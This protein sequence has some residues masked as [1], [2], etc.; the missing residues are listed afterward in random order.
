M[1]FMN[2][3]QSAHGDREFGYITARLGI[4]RKVVAGHV[5]DPATRAR[6][7]SWLSAATGWH[8]SRNL[9][10]A[11]FGDNMRDVAVTDG[12]RVEAQ[13]TFGWSIQGHSI[14]DLV[15]AVRAASDE[16]VDALTADYEQ[17][18]AVVP[19]LRSGGE[20]HESLRDAA[21]IEAGLRSFL[22]E[23][24]LR[25]V[26]HQLPG[27]GRA[28]AAARDRAAEADG[29]RLRL[30]RRGRLEDSCP[31]A[32][33]EGHGQRPHRRHL[34]HG[35]LHLPLRSRRAA[36]P[37]R[38]HARDLPEHHLTPAAG[39]DPSAGDRRPRGSRQTRVRRRPR[40]RFRRRDPRPRR[41]LPAR[42]QHH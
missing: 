5:G 3:N 2:L 7:G 27:S 16:T 14:N 37:R 26:H 21:R 33:G 39:R 38:A 6:I 23:N 13:R 10:V 11:R 25:R 30:R 15:D 18:Y 41:P 1:D 4:R 34:L 42:R 40:P 8:A 29:R 31:A 20:R 19:E 22:T 24:R 9:R 12:D 35:G 36:D 28:Q 17:R 32:S